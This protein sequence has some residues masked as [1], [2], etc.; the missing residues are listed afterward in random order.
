MKRKKLLIVG[1]SFLAV[2]LIGLSA[3]PFFVD[4]NQLKNL[5]I[6]Q[7]ESRLQRKITAKEAV[8]RIFTG[9]G[10]ELREVTIADDPGFSKAPFIMVESLVVKAGILPLLRGKIEI[11]DLR[12]THPVIELIQNREG[13]WNYSSLMKVPGQGKSFLGEF[14]NKANAERIG[15]CKPLDHNP[16]YTVSP[17]CNFIPVAARGDDLNHQ[18]SA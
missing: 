8:V 15:E 18:K 4:S 2:V 10:I 12:I 5:I 11:S 16:E 6:A 3:V 1:V 7:L 17:D 9:P 13:L 14:S